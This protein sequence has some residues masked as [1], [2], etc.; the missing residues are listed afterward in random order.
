M[1]TA[2]ITN[3]AGPT[4]DFLYD[5]GVP[6][7]ESASET[8]LVL[9]ARIAS[10]PFKG[11]RATTVI[12][13]RFDL[14][15]GKGTVSEV[16]ESV[17]GQL[18]FLMEFDRPVSLRAFLLGDIR[19]PLTMIGNRFANVLEGD[20]GRPDRL[21]GNGGAD[22][23]IG[24]S[25]ADDLAGGAGADTFVYRSVDESTE[26]RRDVIRDF[27]NGADLIDL[28]RIDADAGRRG[29][30]AFDFVGDDGF[31]GTAGELRI[32]GRGSLLLGDTD[33]DGAAD[34]AIRLA[35]APSVDEADFLL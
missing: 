34:L 31:T 30:Q 3:A 11:E 16:R 28:E 9:S 14:E 32:G 13:G 15:T 27:G 23:L 5:T 17:D 10:G 29:N 18:H 6:R 2:T 33:G 24:L 25:G 19:E 4:T 21:V 12:V 26:A 8:E 22:E 1:A 35:G 7:E 20:V